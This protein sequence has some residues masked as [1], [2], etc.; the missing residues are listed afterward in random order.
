MTTRLKT[1]S[2]ARANHFYHTNKFDHTNI[3][4]TTNRLKRLESVNRH[5]KAIKAKKTAIKAEKAQTTETIEMTTIAEV[6]KW[7]QRLNCNC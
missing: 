1:P 3:I 2:E 6:T 7:L 4:M 5:L